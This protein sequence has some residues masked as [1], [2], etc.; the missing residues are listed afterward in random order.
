[1]MIM[2]YKLKNWPLCFNQTYIIDCRSQLALVL[3]AKS[4]TYLPKFKAKRHLID[5]PDEKNKLI[6]IQESPM[7][8]NLIGHSSSPTNRNKSATKPE[9]NHDVETVV[10]RSTTQHNTSIQNDQ[11]DNDA[12]ES[13][14][15]SY[16]GLSSEEEKTQE[17]EWIHPGD[18][19]EYTP[20]IF[21]AN[22][23]RTRTMV[24]STDSI[25]RFPLIFKN[26]DRID[27]SVRRM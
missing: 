10:T 25:E 20:P 21:V 24:L 1:M 18:Y 17:Q 5:N 2:Y 27:E 19:I 3:V 7:N 6:P 4:L 22:S 16:S 9:Q 11:N 8:Y 14:D 12:E 13:S 26:N 23:V 15:A